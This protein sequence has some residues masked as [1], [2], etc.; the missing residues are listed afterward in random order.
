MGLMVKK[1]RKTVKS[2]GEREQRGRKEEDEYRKCKKNKQWK[3]EDEFI[4]RT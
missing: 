1:G 3:D 4:A 2:D